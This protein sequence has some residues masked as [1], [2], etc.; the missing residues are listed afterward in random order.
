MRSTAPRYQ[1]LEAEEL[2]LIYFTSGTTANPKM[3]GRDHAYAFAHSITGDYWMDLRESDVHWTL[4][5]TGWAKAAWG[6][7]YPPLLAGSAILLYDGDGF[8]LDMHLKII[9]EQNVTTFCAPPTFTEPSHN[10]T[11][12]GPIL[13]HYGIVSVQASP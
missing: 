10:R 2:M 12:L 3:V 8:D 5:D 11:R 4:T 13:A 7:L 6:L 9:A 1:L